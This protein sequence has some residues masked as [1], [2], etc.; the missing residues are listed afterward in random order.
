MTSDPRALDLP[1]KPEQQPA[2]WPGWVGLRKSTSVPD[3]H[4]ESEARADR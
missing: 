3:K 1:P 2:P 4:D